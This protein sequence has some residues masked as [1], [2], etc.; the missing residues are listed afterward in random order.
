MGFPDGG[1]PVEEFLHALI[2]NV[3][4]GLSTRLVECSRFSVGSLEA[5]GVEVGSG[6]SLHTATEDVSE[7]IPE[8]KT[9]LKCR[10]T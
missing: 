7:L 4:G 10:G 5:F 2:G 8:N 3:R 9:S 6:F 1:E